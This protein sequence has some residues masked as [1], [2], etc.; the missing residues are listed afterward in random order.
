MIVDAYAGL[1]NLHS[2]GFENYEMGYYSYFEGLN[3]FYKDR[4][5]SFLF[6]FNKQLNK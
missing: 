1:C 2:V 5:A 3:I 6:I 4:R